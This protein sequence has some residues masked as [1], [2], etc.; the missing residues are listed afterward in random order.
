MLEE[1]SN[2]V[3]FIINQT[4]NNIPTLEIILLIP[5]LFFFVSLVF[6]GILLLGIIP[7]HVRGLPGILFAPLL[8]ANFNHIFFNS[9]PLVVLSNFIL[10]NGLTYYIVVTVLITVLS[11][12]AVWL[13]AKP[14]LHIGASG[15]ITGYWGFLVSNIYQTATLTT[16]ILGVISIYYFAGI[17]FGIFPK[18][19][20]ISWESHLF[21]LLAGLGVS[22]LLGLYPDFLQMLQV[23]PS[24]PVNY[25]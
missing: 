25:Y 17:F 14:G 9:I 2:S 6:K 4:N 10:I 11:G 8:H 19:K 12:I 1:L 20:G 22:Y 5:W 18:E 23:P 7:R 16:I 21:G 24:P 15:L 3:D 13:F